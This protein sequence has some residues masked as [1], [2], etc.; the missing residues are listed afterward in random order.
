MTP[1]FR[2]LSHP[3]AG[4]HEDNTHTH[5]HTHTEG[6]SLAHQKRVSGSAPSSL[7]LATGQRWAGHSEV[8]GV[9]RVGE[10]GYNSNVV[11][12]FR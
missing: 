11:F 2:M 5:T 9:V 6:Q 7:L 4:I 3:E 12:T 10:Q 8:G 1:C